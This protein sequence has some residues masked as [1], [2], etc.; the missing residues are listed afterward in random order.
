MTV[1]A[2]D[3]V[4]HCDALREIGPC[5]KHPRMF[6]ETPK[7]AWARASST[8]QTSGVDQG[9]YSGHCTECDREDALVV[10]AYREATKHFPVVERQGW[11]CRC[12]KE[13]TSI[14]AWKKHIEALTPSQAR[15]N[16]ERVVAE[17]WN[18]GY[19]EA[20]NEQLVKAEQA[21]I[22]NPASEPSK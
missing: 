20:R 5:G 2:M 9:D 21:R 3:S 13:L 8:G 18:E 4:A 11:R 1:D 17:A 19:N 22:S 6:M 16:A 12:G 7:Q 10:A 14:A 15:A